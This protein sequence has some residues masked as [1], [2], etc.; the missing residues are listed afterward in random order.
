MFKNQPL[1]M[2]A[3]NTRKVVYRKK[4]SSRFQV[5]TSA[6]QDTNQLDAGIV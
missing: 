2:S 3:E 6:L 4:K 1:R 5:T